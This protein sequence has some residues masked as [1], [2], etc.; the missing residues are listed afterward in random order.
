MA[1]TFEFS[2]LAKFRDVASRGLNSLRRNILGVG[3]AAK[4]IGGGRAGAALGMGGPLVGFL[5]GG[6]ALGVKVATGLL[7]GLV[8][9]AR[10][11][12]GGIVS[13]FRTLISA[14]ASVFRSVVSTISGILRTLIKVAAGI[15][16][17]AGAAIGWQLVKGIRENMQLADI[18]AVLQKL[19]GDAAKGAE[20]FARTLSLTTPFTPMQMLQATAGLAAVE[21]DYRRFLTQLT[22]WAAGAKR[23][24]DEIVM[25]FQRAQVGQ[26]GEAM[27]GARRA[28]ISMKDLQAQGAQFSGGNAF[29]G[30]PT[31]FVN[32]LMGAVQERFGGMAE[33]AAEV[34]TGPLST[35]VGAI[36][37]LRV[38]L[39]EPWYERFN[40]GLIDLNTWL[41]ELAKTEKWETLIDA[42]TR[43][44]DALDRGIRRTLE[45]LTTRDWSF[46][47]LKTA[48]S[49]LADLAESQLGRVRDL[50]ASQ[51]TMPF[52]LPGMG[53]GTI[54]KDLLGGKG[55][56]SMGPLTK[57]L[58]EGFRWA[59]GEIEAIFLTL[60]DRVGAGLVQTLLR[61][62]NRV[63]GNLLGGLNKAEAQAREERA[64]DLYAANADIVRKHHRPD[65]PRWEGLSEAE[66]EEWRNKRNARLLRTEQAPYDAARAGL[67]VLGQMVAGASNASAGIQRNAQQ[68]DQ[69]RATA[70]EHGQAAVDALGRTNDAL[71]SILNTLG[72]QVTGLKL[73]ERKVERQDRRIKRLAT[74]GA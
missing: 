20:E 43:W 53:V 34:G 69:I 47:S 58:V 71:G 10:S 26:F 54:V 30:T 61:A 3:K 39:T 67:G 28:L 31:E 68:T 19:L 9:V 21:A 5:F 70:A 57:A 24:L 56:W 46:D 8:T 41:L 18:R 33:Q 45:W 37:D 1:K 29:Q 52:A 27:E 44:S 66:K 32:A 55:A 13:A 36:Q 35:F 65:L 74:A 12:V 7:R 50:F 48:L 64:R 16:L 59:A 63:V 51:E 23:P 17:A 73:L 6:L 11:V 49:E 25:I 15:G 42:S 40:Q 72:E 62:V 60:W 2:I 14:L 38:Q 22:D 4:T